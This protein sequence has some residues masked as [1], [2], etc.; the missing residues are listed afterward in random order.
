MKVSFDLRFAHLPWGSWFYVSE[1]IDVLVREHP[2]TVW[3]IYHNPSSPPQQDIIQRLQTY[4]AKGGTATMEFQPVKYPCL[5]LRQHWEFRRFHDDADVYHYLHFDM[6]LG[7]HGPKLVMTIHDLYPL[8]LE[9]YCGRF[10]RMCFRTLCRRNIQRCDRII[11]VSQATKRDLL[12]ILNAPEDRITVI[13]QGYSP[14]FRPINDEDILKQT[15]RRCDLPAHFILYCGN[16]KPHKN[17]KCLL[18]A[19]RLL[20][21]AMRQYWSLVLTGPADENTAILQK[22][23]RQSGITENVCFIGKVS[24]ADMPALFNLADVLVQPS[25]YEGFG[26]PPLE[27]MACGTAVVSSRGGAL[28]EVVGD[29]ARLF[30]P[31][32]ENELCEQLQMALENDVGNKERKQKCLDQAKRFSWSRTARETYQ[33]YKEIAQQ[34]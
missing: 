16:H 8:V 4:T 19:Y 6:P 14:A 10:K 23:A 27:A 12:K 28:P 20:P 30:D 22:Q 24:A 25:I 13:P 15:R 26:L 34:D 21:A 29:A 17:L 3:R 11:T 18:K 9:G 31:Q 33:V 2:E 7:M 1:V 5:T 32:N